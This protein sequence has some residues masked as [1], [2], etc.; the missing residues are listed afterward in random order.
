MFHVLCQMVTTISFD[1]HLNYHQE[2]EQLATHSFKRKLITWACS[3][4]GQETATMVSLT[5]SWKIAKHHGL[6]KIHRERSIRDQ[7]KRKVK[8]IIPCK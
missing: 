1:D 3:I 6:M 5:L 2:L 8:S 7:Q 4:Y